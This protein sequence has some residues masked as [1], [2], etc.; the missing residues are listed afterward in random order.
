M[1]II[2]IFSREGLTLTLRFL[3]KAVS[4]SNLMYSYKISRQ[5]VPAIVPDICEASIAVH[6]NLVK[7]LFFNVFRKTMV[8]VSNFV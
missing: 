3:V 8:K 2:E 1:Q 5:R 7:A 6:S 4:Y